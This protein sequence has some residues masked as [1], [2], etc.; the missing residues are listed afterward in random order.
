MIKK[1]ALVSQIRKAYEYTT[2]GQAI[3]EALF[4]YIKSRANVDVEKVSLNKLS[5]TK[6]MKEFNVIFW[7]F[8]AWRIY[9]E[10][11]FE[12]TFA[13]I[14]N[15]L[16]LSVPKEM[17]TLWE[18]KCKLH[19]YFD[20]RK[21]PTLRTICKSF[22]TKSI[23][24]H[25]FPMFV[26]PNP[27]LH[28]IN[29]KKVNSKNNLRRYENNIKNKYDS[30]L[31]QPFVSNFATESNPEIRTIWTGTTFRHG[32]KTVGSGDII[33][34]FTKGNSLYPNVER[35]GKYV[36]ST[37]QKDFSYK[38]IYI[39]IDFGLRFGKLFINEV[40]I[41]PGIFPTY[42]KNIIKQ[43]GDQLVKSSNIML[44]QEQ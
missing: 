34:K 12:K 42:N 41:F 10:Y 27:G 2:D 22:E 5:D 16:K 20:S 9:L 38:S 6:Y 25:V 24:K 36:I 19:K 15:K 8:N 30:Y 18:D 44:L 13:N 33:G 17:I 3:D 32:I 31:I 39:R 37:I 23:R 21:F 40:E 43:I 11:G 28:S 4:E 29:A 35:I 7:G 26:K 14:N 1:I